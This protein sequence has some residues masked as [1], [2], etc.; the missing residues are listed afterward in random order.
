MVVIIVVLVVGF[1]EKTLASLFFDNLGAVLE[2]GLPA[3]SPNGLLESV[4][5]QLMEAMCNN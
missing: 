3:W 1:L 5:S 4:T 2:V